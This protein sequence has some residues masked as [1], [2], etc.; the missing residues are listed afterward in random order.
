M[1]RIGMRNTWV[2]D[3]SSMHVS[4]ISFAI[5]MARDTL[6]D[7][8]TSHLVSASM[9]E[10]GSFARACACF[11][12]VAALPIPS[13]SD[14]VE[15]LDGA[16]ANEA[17]DTESDPE[18]K[19]VAKLKF[20]TPES[21]DSRSSSKYPSCLVTGRKYGDVG[22][23]VASRCRETDLNVL[24]FACIGEQS[25][26]KFRDEHLE[27]ARLRFL[28]KNAPAVSLSSGKPARGRHGS[29]TGITPTSQQQL[30][31]RCNAIAQQTSLCFDQRKRRNQ[32]R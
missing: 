8:S 30:C 16:V 23:F 25:S 17:V 10:S 19:A 31:A 5:L 27:N 28:N 18:K 6:V 4:M 12:N 1:V 26:A 11:S 24:E 14:Q 22:E 9:I 29:R 2:F 13:D 15:Y 7:A 3:K 21:L 32:H 20:E